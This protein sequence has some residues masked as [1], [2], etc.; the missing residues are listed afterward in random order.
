MRLCSFQYPAC[1]DKLIVNDDLRDE[2]EAMNAMFIIPG[3][4][5]VGA[6]S[7]EDFQLLGGISITP[8]YDE[9]VRMAIGLPNGRDWDILRYTLRQLAF[10]VG[11]LIW[12]GSAER[13]VGQSM[14]SRSPVVQSS[15]GDTLRHLPVIETWKITHKHFEKRVINALFSQAVQSLKQDGA[16]RCLI[17]TTLE[18]RWAMSI[19]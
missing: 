19:I 14:R 11:H 6:H 13:S 9:I 1:P 4:L 7:L 3:L 16:G 12:M 10:L 5:S 15:V 8:Q 2:L 17:V 18:A